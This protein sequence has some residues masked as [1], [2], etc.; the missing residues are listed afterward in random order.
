MVAVA[1]D[2]PSIGAGIRTRQHMRDLPHTCG[3]KRGGT[4]DHKEYKTLDHVKRRGG[5]IRLPACPILPD[6]RQ[7]SSRDFAARRVAD[8]VHAGRYDSTRAIS[9]IPTRGMNAPLARAAVQPS[10]EPTRYVMYVHINSSFRDHDL[11]T[12]SLGAGVHGAEVDSG[13][14]NAGGQLDLVSAR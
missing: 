11:L 7:T 13:R 9:A 10:H 14:K 5:G 12:D 6:Q 4:A 1:A 2:N 8:E 3:C